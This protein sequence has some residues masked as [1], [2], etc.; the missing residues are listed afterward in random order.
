MA[1]PVGW[2]G[3]DESATTAGGG[4]KRTLRVAGDWVC[5]PAVT[6]GLS[7][8]PSWWICSVVARS[9]FDNRLDPPVRLAATAGGAFLFHPGADSTGPE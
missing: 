6:V 3:S 1:Q 2:A 5:G 4:L 9:V 8:D 7:T